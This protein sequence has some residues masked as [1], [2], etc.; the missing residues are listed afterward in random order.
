MN[1]KYYMGLGLFSSQEGTPY[2]PPASEPLIWIQPQ[3]TV[4]TMV[5]PTLCPAAEG[6]QR[7]L[8]KPLLAGG[9]WLRRPGHQ[10]AGRQLQGAISL[11]KDQVKAREMEVWVHL[12]AGARGAG[13]G[14]EQLL[15]P[16]GQ[17]GRLPLCGGLCYPRTPS[18]CAHRSCSALLQALARTGASA[19]RTVKQLLR[20]AQGKQTQSPGQRQRP[21]LSH[22]LHSLLNAVSLLFLQASPPTP[23]FPITFLLMSQQ[24]RPALCSCR[25]LHMA[26]RPSSQC[27]PTA[28][29]RIAR[30]VPTSSKEHGLRDPLASFFSNPMCPVQAQVPGNLTKASY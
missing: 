13:G 29:S 23:S 8:A 5:A 27:S 12:G 14:H 1:S 7:P 11:G 10:V 21:L 26:D 22:L 28:S 9:S 16:G 24:G 20:W 2:L 6:H 18:A 25:L 3:S 19:G 17:R 4:R 30:P 15:G